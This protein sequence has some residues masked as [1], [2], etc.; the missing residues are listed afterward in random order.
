MRI[1]R[2]FLSLHFFNVCCKISIDFTLKTGILKERAD[3]CGNDM[4]NILFRRESIRMLVHL[5]ISAIYKWV[6]PR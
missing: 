1:I 3:T 6:L 2:A 4:Q 5:L